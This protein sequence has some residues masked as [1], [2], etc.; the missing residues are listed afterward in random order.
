MSNRS[1]DDDRTA[2]DAP[3]DALDE[4]DADIVE[5]LEVAEDTADVLGGQAAFTGDCRAR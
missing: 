1:A 3:Q 4:L 5:D 2:T